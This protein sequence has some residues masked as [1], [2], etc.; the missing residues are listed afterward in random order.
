[1]LGVAASMA[2]TLVSWNLYADYY[3]QHHTAQYASGRRNA[4]LLRRPVGTVR[5]HI[6]SAG[7]PR[8][9][10]TVS[11]PSN[12]PSSIHGR[13]ASNAS[14]PVAA[15]MT[16]SGVAVTVGATIQRIPAYW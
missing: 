3:D 11:G 6:R 4:S 16:S 9:C 8:G 7:R 2:L 13:A 12:A 15:S 14:Q 1:M 10:C 5:V